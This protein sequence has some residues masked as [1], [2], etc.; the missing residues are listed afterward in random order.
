[1][2]FGTGCGG[3]HFVA[4]ILQDAVYGNKNSPFIFVPLRNFGHHTCMGA[5]KNIITDCDGPCYSRAE[6]GRQAPVIDFAR[7]GADGM[8]YQK[9]SFLAC[10]GEGL[11]A[12]R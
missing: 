7:S 1:M 9:R 4:A 2:Y 3:G 5:A 6:I 10:V 12:C 11:H 8:F